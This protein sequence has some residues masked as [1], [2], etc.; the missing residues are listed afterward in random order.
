MEIFVSRLPVFDADK[1]AC[2]YELAFRTGFDTYYDSLNTNTAAADFMAFVNFGEL[3]DGKNGYVNY[4]REMLMRGFP[5]LLPSETM[6]SGLPAD[7]PVDNALVSACEKLKKHG[8]TLMI[9]GLTPSLLDNPLLKMAEIATVDFESNESA[10]RLS[11]IEQLKPSCVQMMAKNIGSQDAFDEAKKW[12]YSFFLGDFFTKPVPQPDG[13]IPTTKIGQL[14]LLAKVST[15]RLSYDE[16][17]EVIQVDVALTFKLMKFMNSVWFGFRHEIKS[18]KHALVLLG[19]AEIRRWVAMATVKT[20]GEDKPNEL[21]ALALTRAKVAEQ[22]APQMNMADE[23]NELF[24]LGMFSVI[25]ALA[26]APMNTILEDLPL[27]EPI[28]QA[29]LE[30]PGKYHDILELIKAYESGKWDLFAELASST[31]LEEDAVPAMFRSAVK[32]ANEALAEM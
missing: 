23:S 2:G 28:K 8:Y 32:W 16:L 15:P 29:L 14:R 11:I 18:I 19:P 9:N 13:K 4:S 12:G 17:V 27:S 26:D 7:I 21:M 6:I 31:G 24:L 22:M 1:S 25:D 10:D 5:V 30:Q 20:L 3:S